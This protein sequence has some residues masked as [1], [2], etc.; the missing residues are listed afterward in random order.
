[1]TTADDA[2]AELRAWYDEL[3]GEDEET[4]LN[5]LFGGIAALEHMRA[6]FPLERRDFITPGWQVRL[7][8]RYVKA[9]M[10]RHNETRRLPSEMGRTTRSTGDRAEALVNRLNRLDALASLDPVERDTVLMALQDRLVRDVQRYLDRQAIKVQINL[11]LSGPLIAQEIIDAA[12]RLGYGG[13]V[14]QHLVGAKLAIRFP[15]IPVENHPFTAPDVQTGRPGDFLIG[16]TVFHVTVHEQE[17]VFLT[18]SDNIRAGLKPYL[19][20][21]ES[22][23]LVTRQLIADHHLT[24][25]VVT[26]TSIES[27]VGQN[28]DEMSEFADDQLKAMF[29][30]LLVEY[31]RRVEEVE[32]NRGLLIEIPTNL[33]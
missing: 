4:Q 18:C 8:Q 28:I 9:T 16:S 2:L 14:A 12:N 19:L 6:K 5:A 23:M 11:S 20:V 7:I 30:R 15:E 13:P 25:K 32:S 27:F 22:R 24:G 31:N 26:S 1:M 21:P 10:A 3:R 29:Y 17:R 33:A